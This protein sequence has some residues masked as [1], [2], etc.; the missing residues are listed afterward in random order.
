MKFKSVVSISSQDVKTAKEEHERERTEDL[1]EM[2]LQEIRRRPLE[3]EKEIMEQER[4]R[5]M[6]L[7]HQQMNDRR[8]STTDTLL[9]VQEQLLK[10]FSKLKVC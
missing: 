1:K 2:M 6:E 9:E 7:F 3:N 5:R 8:G 4:K 10:I